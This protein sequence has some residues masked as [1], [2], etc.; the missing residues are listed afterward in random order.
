MNEGEDL[1]DRFAIQILNGFLSGDC[2]EGTTPAQLSREA[3]GFADAM[4]AARKRKKSAKPDP[5]IEIAVLA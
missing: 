3:Y 5:V 4:L 2:G 1:R